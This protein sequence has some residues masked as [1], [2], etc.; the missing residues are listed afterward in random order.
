MYLDRK[1]HPYQSH[2]INL[3]TKRMV[4]GK[5]GSGLFLEPGLGKT[6][7]SLSIIEIAKLLSFASKTLVI[8]PLRVAQTVWQKEIREWGLDLKAVF[9]HGS[10][11]QRFEL[12]QKPADI[13]IIT[14]D[15]VCWLDE[16][17]PDLWFDLVI[18]DESAT[19][20]HS[21]AIPICYMRFCMRGRRNFIITITATHT[22]KR[23]RP[24]HSGKFE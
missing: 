1:L 17:Y 14:S 9:V 4:E 24:D 10:K 3:A 15:G 2:V 12:L 13:Y 18:I 20:R 7:C 23:I 21:P 6:I 22:C 5:T 16:E 11:K 19:T 8:A